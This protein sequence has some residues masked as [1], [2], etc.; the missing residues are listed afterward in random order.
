MKLLEVA[1]IGKA[2]GLKGELSVRLISNVSERVESG[3]VLYLQDERKMVVKSS[4][5]HKQHH[6]VLFEGVESR[7]AADALVGELLFG[8]PIND[9]EIMWAHE[10]IGS[11]VLDGDGTTIGEVVAIETNPASDLLVLKG[12]A[13]IPLTFVV[14]QK[15]RMIQVDIPHGLLQEGTNED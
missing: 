5:Q 8:L 3:S 4:K 12:G 7:T 15:D 10:L 13:M 11:S 9:P 1:R 2:H 14:E 6:L